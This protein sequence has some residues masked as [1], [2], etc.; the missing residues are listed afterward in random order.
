MYNFYHPLEISSTSC[1]TSKHRSLKRQLSTAPI[2]LLP[3]RNTRSTPLFIFQAQALGLIETSDPP[4]PDQSSNPT[5]VDV[6]ALIRTK[7]KI[8]EIS[9]SPPPLVQGRVSLS[10]SLSLTVH[11][12]STNK[13]IH[14]TLSSRVCRCRSRLPRRSRLARGNSIAHVSPSHYT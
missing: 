5:S 8:M 4:N 3:S 1:P 6:S 10:L 9:S 2:S 12:R 13:Y 7:R 11:E 14:T